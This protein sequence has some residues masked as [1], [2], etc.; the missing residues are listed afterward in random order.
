M[1]IPLASS[2]NKHRRLF[3]SI[4][5]IVGVFTIGT[6]LNEK[7]PKEV[8]VEFFS[9]DAAEQPLEV[10]LDFTDQDGRLWKATRLNL[11]PNSPRFYQLKLPKGRYDVQGTLFSGGET[12]TASASFNAPTQGNV[13]LMFP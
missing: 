6:M 11:G 8:V 3:A 9:P 7:M 5:A 10:R 1:A 12:T 13:R 4:V 2:F